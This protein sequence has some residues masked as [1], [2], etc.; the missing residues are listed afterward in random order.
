MRFVNDI[1]G[2]L[3]HRLIMLCVFPKRLSH[4]T[5]FTKTLN[6]QAYL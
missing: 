6:L 3:E 4:F 1:I 5:Q 2:H